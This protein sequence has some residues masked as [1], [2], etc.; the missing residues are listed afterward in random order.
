MN[1]IE[2]M[3]WRL[4]IFFF[5][6]TC[7]TFVVGI[8]GWNYINHHGELPQPTLRIVLFAVL[9]VVNLFISYEAVLSFQ[10]KLDVL[11]LAIKQVEK[12]NLSSRIAVFGTDSF[13]AVY[14]DF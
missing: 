14:E 2:N 13:D 9:A 11:H 12:G 3:K 6:S 10:R 1:R 8:T 5:V 4:P 7:I